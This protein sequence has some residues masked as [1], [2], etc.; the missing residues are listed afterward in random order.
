MAVERAIE[1]TRQVVAPTPTWGWSCCWPRWRRSRT[2]STSR[3]RRGRPRR[4]DRRRRPRGLPGDPAGP[5]GRHGRGP[6]PGY[7]R[8]ADDAAP[9]GDGLAADRDLVAR[10]YAN[11]FREVFGEALPALRASLEPGRSVETA[12][13]A[14][15]LTLL[16]RHPDSLIAR[17]AGLDSPRRGLAPRGGGPRRRLAGSPGSGRGCARRS[18][19]GSAIRA[20]GYNPGTTADLVTAA[21]YAALRDGTIP[22]TV[23]PPPGTPLWP[24][25]R[26][27]IGRLANPMERPGVD[28]ASCR[29]SNFRTI[30]YR[31]SPTGSSTWFK[32][33]QVIL[34]GSQ[35]RGTAGEDSDIDLMIV[36]DRPPGAAWSRRREIGRI[37]RALAPRSADRSTSSSSR[38]RK[39]RSGA[40]RR[41]T[42]SARPCA[43]GR[44]SMSDLEHARSLLRMAQ[45]DLN[46]LRGMLSTESSCPRVLFLRRRSSGFTPSRPRRRA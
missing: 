17:K 7:R 29:W 14:T 21:L 5:A 9:R 40:I 44:S 11:G 35:A 4:D 45:A 41:T 23:L 10:Q 27:Q 20:A 16:A 28:E 37:R 36:G 32:P 19:T 12:I 43:K 39:S 26:G 46:A 30:S 22:A 24:V 38:R 3:R 13:V 33:R 25:R 1:A 8:R 18:T 42:S 6:R 31:H 34:F 15:H 2:A